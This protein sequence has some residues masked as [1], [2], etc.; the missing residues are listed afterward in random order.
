MFMNTTIK[1][2]EKKIAA[3]ENI[4]AILLPIFQV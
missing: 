3:S 2:T 4:T 1:Y